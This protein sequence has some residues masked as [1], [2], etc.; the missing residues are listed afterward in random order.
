MWHNAC[1]SGNHEELQ[2][3]NGE[4]DVDEEGHDDKACSKIKRV[5]RYCFMHPEDNSVTVPMF[6]IGYQELWKRAHTEVT[7]IKV[8]KFVRCSS[9]NQF[10]HAVSHGSHLPAGDGC[11][12][13]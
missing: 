7:A 12:A 9:S 11:V 5:Y 6:F 1:R 13:L 3:A 4:A 10:K 8:W 2:R